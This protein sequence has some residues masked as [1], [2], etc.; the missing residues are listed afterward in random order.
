MTICRSCSRNVHI[1]T[2][3]KSQT[4]FFFEKT[5]DLT[6]S[7]MKHFDVLIALGSV[8]KFDHPN[9]ISLA[10]EKELGFEEYR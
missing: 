10:E 9:M 2:K 6:I 4:S 1:M 5:L 3:K 8:Y 7:E